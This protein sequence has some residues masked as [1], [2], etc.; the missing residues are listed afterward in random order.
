MPSFLDGVRYCDNYDIIFK[1]CIYFCVQ[2]STSLKKLIISYSLVVLYFLAIFRPFLPIIEY[3]IN[4]DYIAE[5]L[6][7][8][9]N[10]PILACNGKCYLARE[11]VET[12]AERPMDQSSTLPSI[13]LEKIPL[14]TIPNLKNKIINILI[15]SF[16]EVNYKK[17]GK[18]FSVV[19]S[20]F[21]PPRNLA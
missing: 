8:N 2:K 16:K 21:R 7:E 3:Y 13:E 5:Q 11:I 15:L 19:I 20:I 12:S 9:R 14:S 4:Y 18:A 6:C 1:K 17:K 10:K